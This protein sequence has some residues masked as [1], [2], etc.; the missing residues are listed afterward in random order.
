MRL[1]TVGIWDFGDDFLPVVHGEQQDS[2]VQAIGVL[3]DCETTICLDGVCGVPRELGDVEYTVA[4]RQLVLLVCE[5][6]TLCEIEKLG[7]VRQRVVQDGL[8]CPSSAE[9]VVGHTRLLDPVVR[10]QLWC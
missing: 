1:T 9:L 6:S 4:S 10:G 2:I 7:V 3:S 8:H 5:E